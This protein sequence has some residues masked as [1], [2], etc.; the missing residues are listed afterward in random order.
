MSW[1]VK[2]L[3]DSVNPVGNRLTTIEVVFPRFILPELL[4]VRMFSRNFMSSRARPVMHLIQSVIDDPVIPLRWGKAKKGMVNGYDI[5]HFQAVIAQDNWLAAR[6]NAVASAQELLKLGI[7]KTLPNRLVEPFS[8]TTGIVS[9]TE[10]QNFWDLRCAPDAEDHMQHLAYMMR[11]AMEFSEPTALE[12]G[13]WHTPL[14]QDDER[15]LHF[16]DRIR[17][18][19]ARCGRVS[20]LTHLGVRDVN[21]DYRLHDD[22]KKSRHLSPFEHPAMCLATSE[23]HGNFIG[24]QQYRKMIE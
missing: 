12:P 7:H 8:F 20:Y 19:T 5:E 9:A 1:S 17:L 3:A 16:L 13:Q 4:T 22:L 11:E 6:D 14:I 23:R 10:W 24:W 18:S 21:E 15:E 2:V